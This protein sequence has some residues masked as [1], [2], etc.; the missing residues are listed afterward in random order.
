MV[1]ISASSNSMI[2]GGRSV[3]MGMAYSFVEHDDYPVRFG[4]VWIWHNL[5]VPE[6]PFKYQ[7][8]VKFSTKFGPF[9]I[10]IPLKLKEEEKKVKMMKTELELSKVTVASLYKD[11]N[12]LQKEIDEKNSKYESMEKAY[13]E[14]TIHLIELKTSVMALE[15][16]TLS[17]KFVSLA[18]MLMKVPLAFLS[19]MS[20]E[21]R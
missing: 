12:Y 16:Q 19:V 4:G 2:G 18:T 17:S 7:I 11:K 14:Q 3:L 10:R 9:N 8:S 21:S 6:P 15:A 5:G 20:S 1:R 13:K